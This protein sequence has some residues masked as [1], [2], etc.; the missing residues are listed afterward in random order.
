MKFDSQSSRKRHLVSQFLKLREKSLCEIE[1]TPIFQ[2]VPS[3]SP[4]FIIGNH[5]KRRSFGI[6][7]KN[8]FPRGGGRTSE[9]INLIAMTEPSLQSCFRA[10][11]RRRNLDTFSTNRRG[12]S[13]VEG[14]ITVFY[15]KVLTGDAAALC[16]H[17]SRH[18]GTKI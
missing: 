8:C 2:S 15:S 3:I 17:D 13:L 4:P 11:R 6:D 14:E 5:T 1:F 12:D 10:K 7:G 18:P 9:K 16:Q